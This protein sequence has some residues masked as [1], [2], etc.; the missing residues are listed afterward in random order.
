MVFNLR[1]L[2][3][4]TWQYSFQIILVDYLL[5]RVEITNFIKFNIR[6]SAIPS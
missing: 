6:F 1:I 3:V 5:R 4:Q 2:I